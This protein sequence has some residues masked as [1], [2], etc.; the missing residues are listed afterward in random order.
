MESEASLKNQRGIS[1]IEAAIT[2]PVAILVMLGILQ[3]GVVVYAGQMAKEA[4]RHGARTG[5]V[6]QDYAAG[7]AHAAASTFAQSAFPIGE[8]EVEIL[9]PGGVVGS[10]LRV[11][12]TYQVP[13]WLAG[14][15]GLPARSGWPAV[16]EATARQEGW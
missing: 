11:R 1:T 16:G 12:V 9:A 15:P 2:L 3:V 5:S 14:M 7:R 6:A 8:P 10:Q 13:N 4:A